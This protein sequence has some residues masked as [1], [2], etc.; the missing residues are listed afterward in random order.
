M[1]NGFML[2]AFGLAVF[3]APLW[4]LVPLIVVKTAA[5]VFSKPDVTPAPAPAPAPAKP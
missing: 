2:A 5:D 3:G 4:L 1:L